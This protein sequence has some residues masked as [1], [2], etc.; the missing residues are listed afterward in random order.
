MTVVTLCK[1]ITF[2]TSL[3]KMADIKET[4][5]RFAILQ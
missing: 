1:N 4:K 2:F 5:Q 3:Q